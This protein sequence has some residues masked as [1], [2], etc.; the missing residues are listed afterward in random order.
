MK[1]LAVRSKQG[2]APYWWRWSGIS[3]KDPHGGKSPVGGT[4]GGSKKGF[5]Y[6]ERK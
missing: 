4:V 3:V 6:G 5:L 2:E 1:C